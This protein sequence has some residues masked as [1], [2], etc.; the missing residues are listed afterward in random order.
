[1]GKATLQL[2]RDVGVRVVA[3][4]GLGAINASGFSK[5]GDVYVNDAYGKSS[6]ALRINVEGGVGEINLEMGG[7]SGA[8]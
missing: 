2:P 7:S 6:V 1:V 5:E 8:V 4:G 3:H